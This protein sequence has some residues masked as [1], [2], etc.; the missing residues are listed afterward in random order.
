MNFSDEWRWNRFLG[1]IILVEQ[2]SHNHKGCTRDKCPWYTKKRR[3]GGVAA[4]GNLIIYVLQ[5]CVL[6]KRVVYFICDTFFYIFSWW[7]SLVGSFLYRRRKSL[8]ALHTELC[9]IYCVDGYAGR[10]LCLVCNV[11]IYIGY[12]GRN[13]MHTCACVK[14]YT[15]V[16]ILYKCILLQA[17]LAFM[18]L[19]GTTAPPPGCAK[20]VKQRRHQ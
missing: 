4:V 10:T 11:C 20:Y 19:M 1:G 16:R 18:M 3:G 12:S 8:C 17:D 9:C 2:W 13:L 6:L 15:C 7:W 5:Q 14:V